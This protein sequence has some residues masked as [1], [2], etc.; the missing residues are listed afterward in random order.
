MQKHQGLSGLITT[1]FNESPAVAEQ[2]RHLRIIQSPRFRSFMIP[3]TDARS[4]HEPDTRP[5][6]HA[7]ISDSRRPVSQ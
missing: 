3:V 6:L 7:I 4:P 2:R 5:A 1:A